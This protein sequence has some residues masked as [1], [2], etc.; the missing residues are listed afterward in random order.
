[1]T[2]LPRIGDVVRGPSYVTNPR[3]ETPNGPAGRPSPEV[4]GS[5]APFAAGQALPKAHFF[6][7]LPSRPYDQVRPSGTPR[8]GGL[9]KADFM[10]IPLL[11]NPHNSS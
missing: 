7:S 9:N 6:G 4:P 5:Y 10:A 8:D 1:M 3:P 2:L 11:Y